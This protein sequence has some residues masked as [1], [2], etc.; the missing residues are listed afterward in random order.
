M[1]RQTVFGFKIEKTEETLTAHG[2]LALFAEYNHGLGLRD[3]ANQYLPAPG[4]NRGYTA[5]AFVDSLVLMLQGGGRRLEDVRE[6][7]QESPLLSLIDRTEIP[8]ADTIGDWLRRMGDPK[9]G[10]KGFVGLGS[11]RDIL[12]HRI[13]KRDARTDYTLDVDAMQVAAEK[14]DAHYTYKGEK[15]YMPLLGFL[16]EPALCLMD[17]FREGNASPAAGHVAFYHAC[18]SCMPQGKRIARYR[19]DSASY[20]ASEINALEQ[21]DVLWTITA[22]QDSAIKQIISALP[23]D[24]WKTPYRGCDYELAE[25]VHTMNETKKA[26]RLV[27]KRELRR[28]RD[29][30]DADGTDGVYHY[31][32]VATNWAA[33]KQDGKET[34]SA[35]EVLQWHNQ[36]GQAE[37][38]NKELK[39]GFGQNQMPCGESYANA[40]YFRI[41][42]IAYNL[43]LGFKRLSSLAAWSHQTIASFR[44]KLIQIAGRIVR[45]ANRTILKLAVDDEKLSL[46]ERIRQCCYETSL[47]T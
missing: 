4:S 25:A 19:A 31:H 10:R 8:D 34:K 5:S 46:I 47:A 24:A 23:A 35:H 39:Y 9:T 40:V 22:D 44:W 28:Q 16:F 15:G 33:D 3:L 26:F 18:K 42:V 2:G 29:L 43:F 37:N 7:R 30:F 45:H 14:N 20:Q 32:V 13:L 17:E 36:R 27:I 21:D 12:N 1:I 11:V 6:L 41:G 38:F